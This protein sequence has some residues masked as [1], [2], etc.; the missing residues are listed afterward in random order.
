MQKN[1]TTN[2]YH[3]TAETTETPGQVAN[4]GSHDTPH[5]SGLYIRPVS[6]IEQPAPDE[7]R[8]PVDMDMPQGKPVV[9][10]VI[11]AVIVA[12]CIIIGF[13]TI[14]GCL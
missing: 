9:G 2:R 7:R 1:D 13:V 3:G 8:E 4:A 11:L 6:G 12:A 10:V 14:R 5:D